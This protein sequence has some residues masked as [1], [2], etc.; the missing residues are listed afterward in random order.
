MQLQP[1]AASVAV[2]AA[3]AAA[4]SVLMSI[5]ESFRRSSKPIMGELVGLSAV[6]PL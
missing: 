2:V 4:A 1:S 5:S 3:E 6:P